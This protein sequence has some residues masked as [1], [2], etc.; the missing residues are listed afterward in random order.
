VEPPDHRRSDDE[1]DEHG[2]DGRAGRAE[3]DVAEEVEK[4][5]FAGEPR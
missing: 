5:A 3:G 4:S 1:G 2:R